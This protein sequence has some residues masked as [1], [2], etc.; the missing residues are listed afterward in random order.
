M[1]EIIS[2][3]EARRMFATNGKGAMHQTTWRTLV[4]NGEFPRPITL[5]K[6]QYYTP[7]MLDLYRAK[8]NEPI[9]RAPKR[10]ASG[11]ISIQERLHRNF[12]RDRAKKAG[13]AAK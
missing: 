8:L 7:E 10:G 6:R 1:P 2:I 3:S 9:A 13:E 12:A 11:R 5:G 4:E